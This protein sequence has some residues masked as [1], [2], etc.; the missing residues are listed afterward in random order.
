MSALLLGLAATAFAGGLL[1]LLR[2]S[3]Y[4]HGGIAQLVGLACLAGL[5][6]WLWSDLGRPPLRTLGETRLW[7]AA[8]LVAIGSL[9]E[10]HLGSRALR[11]PMLGFALLFTCL[12]LA[13]PESFDRTLMPALRSPWFVPH[14]VVNLVAYAALGLAGGAAAIALVRHHGRPP[15]AAIA[16]PAAL[17]EVGLVFLTFGLAFGALWAKEAWGHYW[18]WDPKETWAWVSWCACVIAM[19]LG[20]GADARTRAWTI[21]LALA[22]ILASWFLTPLLPAA[23]VS[24]HTYAW[25][26]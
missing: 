20:R 1:A 26:G 4:R 25:G 16:L 22:A 21:L 7:Y 15:A 5:L 14:V 6:A 12:A 11:A 3:W 24:V 23:H 8:L 9:L 10:L 19:H 17:V 2:P 18:S 13:H